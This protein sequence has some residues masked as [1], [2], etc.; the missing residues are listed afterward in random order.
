MAPYDDIADLPP[1]VRAHL[2]GHAQEIYLAAFNHAWQQHADEAR[3]E[4]IAHRIAWAAVKRV[5]EKTG[6]RW[7]RK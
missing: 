4:E 1:R 5:Y 2:P 7:V 3:R 6:D